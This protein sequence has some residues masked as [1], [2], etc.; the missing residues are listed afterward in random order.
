MFCKIVSVY[1]N[2]HVHYMLLNSICNLSKLTYPKPNS[3]LHDGNRISSPN[4]S[5]YLGG[6]RLLH[7]DPKNL[8]NSL[9]HLYQINN[10]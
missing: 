8:F 5:D 6:G 4:L 2:N 10:V 9:N 1:F 7:L 3:F